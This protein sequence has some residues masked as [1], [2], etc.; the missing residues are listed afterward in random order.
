MDGT[1]DMLGQIV[2]GLK[3][4]ND[5]VLRAAGANPD[6]DA[7]GLYKLNPVEVEPS[8]RIALMKAPGFTPCAY[9]VIS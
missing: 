1:K 9:K 4:V 8:W 2:K 3:S 7:V 6:Q 5:E